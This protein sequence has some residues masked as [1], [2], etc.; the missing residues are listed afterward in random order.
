MNAY[1][2]TMH[3]DGLIERAMLSSA[4]SSLLSNKA[5][6]SLYRK[7]SRFASRGYDVK[8][9]LEHMHRRAVEKKRASAT[10]LAAWIRGIN[11]GQRFSDLVGSMIPAAERMAIASGEESGRLDDGFAMAAYIVESSAKLRTAVYA[12]LA[13]PTV[14][15]L[16]LLVMLGFIAYLLIPV[17]VQ[18]YPVEFWPMTSAAL[19][20]LSLAVKS[21]GAPALAL[22]VAGLIVANLTLPRW[23]GPV[24]AKLDHALPPWSIYREIQSG[25]LL[26]SLSGVVRAGAPLDDA[27]R[28]LKRASSPWLEAHIDQMITGIAEGERPALAME[29]G[30]MSAALMDDLLAY[31]QAGDLS[32]AILGLGQDAVDLVAEKIRGICAVTGVLLMISVGASLVWTWGSF[33]MVFMAMRSGTTPI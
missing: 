4:R 6:L 8:V 28:R 16:L 31:D 21:Y 32:T 10:I 26:V 30:L 11:D 29:T 17:L 20:Y 15:L 24:R 13:Y 19:Y 22:L 7:L 5:R 12:G 9:P 3:P 1:T 14:L 18:M 27:L 25:L 33:V 23:T 2:A